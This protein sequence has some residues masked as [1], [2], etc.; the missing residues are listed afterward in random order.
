MR[1]DTQYLLVLDQPHC[2]WR[3]WSWGWWLDGPSPRPCTA[4]PNPA[5]RVAWTCEGRRAGARPSSPLARHSAEP[6]FLKREA[7]GVPEWQRGEQNTVN[8]GCL[9]RQPPPPAPSLMTTQFRF[10][11]EEPLFIPKAHVVE[12]TLELRQSSDIFFF[13]LSTDGFWGEGA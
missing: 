8:Q 11:S 3:G 10:C 13:N 7:L 4:F 6:P 12:K 1:C 2:S 5:S 9:R